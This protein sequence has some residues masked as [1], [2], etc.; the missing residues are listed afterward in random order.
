M[1]RQIVAAVLM[2][3]TACGTAASTN[4]SG[5]DQGLGGQDASADVSLGKCDAVSFGTISCSV[6]ITNHSD[7][8]SDYYIEAT[9]T[10]SDGVN[11]GT[12][13]ALASK[14][15]GGGRAKTDLLGT[16]SGGMKDVTVKITTVQRTAS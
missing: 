3:A 6:D 7:G 2:A 10:D 1:K 8:T 4:S 13:N 15:A 9:I 16:I 14:V 11:V 5:V 12:G